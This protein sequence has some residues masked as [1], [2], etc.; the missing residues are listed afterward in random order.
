MCLRSVCF[1]CRIATLTFPCGTHR[2]CVSC[3]L[4]HPEPAQTPATPR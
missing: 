1:F 3:I 4:S 2:A